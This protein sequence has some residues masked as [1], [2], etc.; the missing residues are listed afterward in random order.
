M[1][2]TNPKPP[3]Q[4]GK[5]QIPETTGPEHRAT[6]WVNTKYGDESQEAKMA[7]LEVI[8]LIE[9]HDLNIK[10]EL[11]KKSADVQPSDW[12]RI[13]YF[14]LFRNKFRMEGLQPVSE[15]TREPQFQPSAPAADDDPFTVR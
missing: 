14:G 12:P 3:L 2:N 15:V 7:V 10:I 8:R 9:K 6:A 11:K 13:G 4:N 5:V 1:Q